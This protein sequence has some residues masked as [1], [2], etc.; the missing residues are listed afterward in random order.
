MRKKVIQKLSQFGCTNIISLIN[1][2]IIKRGQAATL[3]SSLPAALLNSHIIIFE[4]CF[5]GKSLCPLTR[6]S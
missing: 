2:L 1:K 3:S 4:R 6:L 5:N